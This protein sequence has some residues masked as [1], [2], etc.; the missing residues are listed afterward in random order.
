MSDYP[1]ELGVRREPTATQLKGF[2]GWKKHRLSTARSGNVLDV[3][4]PASD[5]DFQ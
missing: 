3:E 5:R 1:I 4:S 2:Q